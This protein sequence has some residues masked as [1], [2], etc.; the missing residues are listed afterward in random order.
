MCVKLNSHIGLT[1]HLTELTRQIFRLEPTQPKL[2]RLKNLPPNLQF[3]I[4]STTF[5][6][7]RLHHLQKANN[8]APHLECVASKHPSP[9]QKETDLLINS[10]YK[11]YLYFIVH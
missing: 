2:F 7:A 1:R 9:R 11:K 8:N 4:N 5:L 6:I 10:E 3:N